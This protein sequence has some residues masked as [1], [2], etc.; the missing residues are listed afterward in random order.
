[1]TAAT[2]DDDV[3]FRLRLWCAPGAF[4]S[5]MVAEGLARHGESGIAFHADSAPSV[6]R[7]PL[8]TGGCPG[9]TRRDV[10]AMT[11]TDIVKERRAK[12]LPRAA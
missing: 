12:A 2:N 8:N 4:P 7:W 10:I 1:M 5:L 11:K 9:L 3:I 6:F